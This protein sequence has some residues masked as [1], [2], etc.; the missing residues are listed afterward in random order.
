MNYKKNR[1]LHSKNIFIA[2]CVLISVSLIVISTIQNNSNTIIISKN[3]H[4]FDSN[5][6]ESPK[7]SATWA[8][9]NI[10]STWIDGNR[11][12]TNTQLTISGR[13]YHKPLD[14]G[15]SGYYINLIIDGQSQPSYNNVTNFN[16]YYKIQNFTIPSYMNIYT[17]HTIEVEVQNP[18]GAVIIEN[19]LTFYVNT[20]SNIIITAFGDL[21]IPYLTGEGYFVQGV[22]N[23]DNGSGIENRDLDVMWYTN[24]N[25]WLYKNNIT[26]D[27][28]GNFA[29]YFQIP[30]TYADK[31]N[32]MLN[33]TLP[34][35]INYSENNIY[36]INIFSNITC[37][38]NMG[39]SATVGDKILI[40]GIIKSQTNNSI[41]INGRQL[42]IYYDGQQIATVVT[43]A[44]GYFSYEYEIPEGTGTKNIQVFLPNTAGKNI[45]SQIYQIS[46]QEAATDTTG[47]GKTTEEEN[48]LPPY[49]MF[50]IIFFP[51]LGGVIA[52][53]AI[54][55]YKYLQ[56]QEEESRVVRLPLENKIRNLKILKDTRRLEEAISYLFD[57]IFMELIN[58]KYNKRRKISETIRD[59]AIISVKECNLS[60][61]AIYPFIQRIEKVIYDRPFTITDR[62]FYDVCGLFS[63]IYFE[64]TGFNFI[65]NF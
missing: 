3:S 24:T 65:L 56:K 55:G 2:L 39:V 19:N 40:Q 61:T 16:G 64:L 50:S 46:I 8:W 7:N 10:T 31:I 30:E 63:P 20:T 18:D 45:F 62:D 17:A 22:L 27:P 6:E 26:T 14:I 15:R 43:Q 49:F 59:F 35:L 44:D 11:F 28:A 1:R 25:N 37:V 33:F 54:F 47:K 48:K 34:A 53:L 9:L 29:R 23:Y 4:H 41:R 42:N 12:Y 57:A 21:S 52:V 5:K 32:F 36:N 60:P 38:W 13:L 51:I 58:A